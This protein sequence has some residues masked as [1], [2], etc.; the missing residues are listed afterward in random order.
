MFTV[1][2]I[3][4]TTLRS[5]MAFLSSAPTPIDSNMAS[6]SSPTTGEGLE[7]KRALPVI[8]AGFRTKAPIS[9]PLVGRY[10]NELLSFT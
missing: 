1:I 6:L 5:R 7:A 3:Q 4:L 10:S 2:R 9:P 8:R